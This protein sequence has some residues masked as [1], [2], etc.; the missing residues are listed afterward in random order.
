MYI[1]TKQGDVYCV[2]DRTLT[3]TETKV[4]YYYF[5]LVTKRRSITGKI[6]ADLCIDMSES[7]IAWAERNFVPKVQNG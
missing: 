7:D 3:F 4:T 6:G 5:N 2:E 1:V